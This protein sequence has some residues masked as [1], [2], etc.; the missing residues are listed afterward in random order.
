[1][2]A[3]AWEAGHRMP[4]IVRWP[5]KVKKG[6]VSDQTICFTDLLATCAAVTHVDLTES[7]GPDSYS[8]LP[9]LRGE[10]PDEQPIRPSI[11]MQSG[12]GTMLIRSGE[13]KLINQLGS[14]GFSE[15]RRVEPGPGDPEGQLYNLADDPEE[16][17][18]VYSENPEIVTRLLNEMK[19]IIGKE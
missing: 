10:Q 15:P 9:V 8:F 12:S 11:V 3:D 16:T 4:F 6:S 18:N 5:G 14:G 17:D 13:W 7:A 19:E 1:M 2:K